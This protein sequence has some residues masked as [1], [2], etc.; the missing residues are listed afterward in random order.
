MLT[1]LHLFTLG[2]AFLESSVFFVPLALVQQFDMSPK[3]AYLVAAAFAVRMSSPIWIWFIDG[4]PAMHGPL[5]AILSLISLGALVS[6]IFIPQISLVWV[7]L[8]FIVYHAAYQ[9][10]GVILD[11]LIIKVLGDYRMLLFAAQRQWGLLISPL[12][13]SVGLVY[14]IYPL[15]P[16]LFILAGFVAIGSLGF[17][18]IGLVCTNPEPV[19]PSEL[20]NVNELAPFFLKN[21]L[22][23]TDTRTSAGPNSSIYNPLYQPYSLF[24]EQLSHISEEDASLLQRMASPQSIMRNPS[25]SSH[26]SYG[27]TLSQSNP[28][29]GAFPENSYLNTNPS[30]PGQN[31][32]VSFTVLPVSS[33]DLALIPNPSPEDPMGVL[34][35]LRHPEDYFSYN[36]L[37]NLPSQ[38][39]IQSVLLSLFLLG[40]VSGMINCLLPI[41]VWRGLGGPVW[42]VC[43]GASVQVMCMF[44]GYTT[45]RWWIHNC[46]PM[47]LS[48]GLHGIF[49]ASALCYPML[50]PHSTVSLT[51]SVFLQGTQALCLHLAW[52]MATNRLNAFAWIDQQR[53]MERGKASALYGCIGPALGALIAGYIVG[54]DMTWR[55]GFVHLFHTTVPF[56]ALSFVISWGWTME[57]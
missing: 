56:A 41:Y 34:V 4:R 37:T 6:I 35:M 26:Y 36:Y 50:V 38:W 45:I 20:A 43:V 1:W 29:A 57:D 28:P 30:N 13:L 25:I 31:V 42:L 46:S 54:D 10:L 15:P 7:S 19:D 32:E 55:V 51:A 11:S 27:S 18:C 23:P 3:I 53:M 33:L 12:M 24:G 52:C 5:L 21:A 49:I 16:L 40:I 2:H 9:P 22:Q 39:R 48:S 44:F 14:W 8:L 47:L 17:A